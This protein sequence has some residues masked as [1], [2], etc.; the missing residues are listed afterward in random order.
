MANASQ[1]LLARVS[2]LEKELLKMARE[3]ARLRSK[4][5]SISTENSLKNSNKTHIHKKNEQATTNTIVSKNSYE[6]LSIEDSVPLTMSPSTSQVKAKTPIQMQKPNGVIKSSKTN[7]NVNN[8]INNLRQVHNKKNDIMTSTNSNNTPIKKNNSKKFNQ[9]PIIAYGLNRKDFAATAKEK[10]GHSDFVMKNVN[11]NCTHIISSSLED[12]KLLREHLKNENQKFYF[13]TPKD[14]KPINVIIRGI[15]NSYDENDIISELNNLNIKIDVLRVMRYSTNNSKRKNIK[16]NLWLLKMAPGSDVSAVMKIKYLLNQRVS[17]EK[18]K[19]SEIIQCKR[20]QR[21]GHAAFNCVLDYRCVKCEHKHEPGEC[22][23]EI[24]SESIENESGE[25]ETKITSQAFCVNCQ[26]N[27]HPANFRQ[28]PIYK[29]FNKT[30]T[31]KIHQLS[32]QQIK[33]SNAYNSYITKGVSFSNIVNSNFFPK[34][35]NS[36]NS[37]IFSEN[38]YPQKENHLASKYGDIFQ[39]K[40]T[41]SLDID[42]NESNFGFLDNECNNIFGMSFVE[43]IGQVNEFVPKYKCITDRNEKSQAL[44][45]FMLKITK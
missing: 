13:Y 20:C 5:N 39:N 11:K 23:V 37:N 3:N 41:K 25:L 6:L 28:C 2:C 17:F 18:P 10:L 35:S 31:E 7:T 29:K 4:Q 40:A 33:K 34:N 30:K 16:L 12:H 19:I 45:L 21:Y 24:T 38:M 27:G 32:S 1:A 15:D 43:V 9:K 42:K 36:S 14:E 26:K 44:L 8:D 22:L